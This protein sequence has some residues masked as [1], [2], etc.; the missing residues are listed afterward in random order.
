[1]NLLSV[2]FSPVPCYRRPISPDVLTQ[3][4]CLKK[5]RSLRLLTAPG[6]CLSTAPA[7]QT[8][9][10]FD[11]PLRHVTF[12]TVACRLTPRATLRDARRPARLSR[13]SR[14]TYLN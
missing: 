1:M 11:A 4:P 8:P 5:T 9:V 13:K 2:Q 3:H 7:A 14:Y 10:L 12:V 6:H